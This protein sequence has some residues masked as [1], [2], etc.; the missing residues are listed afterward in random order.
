MV[1]K[2]RCLDSNLF[3]RARYRRPRTELPFDILAA[4]YGVLAGILI[5]LVGTFSWRAVSSRTPNTSNLRLRDAKESQSSQLRIEK[6]GD[7]V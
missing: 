2:R 7:C 1:I 6:E 3:N 5:I 4:G